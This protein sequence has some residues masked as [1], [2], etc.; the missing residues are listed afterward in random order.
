[1]IFLLCVLVSVEAFGYVVCQ[2][3]FL[4]VGTAELLATDTLDMHGSTRLLTTANCSVANAFAYDAWGTLIASNGPPQTV[5]LYTGEQFDPELGLYYLR[6]R[7][8][9]TGTGRFWTRDP[10]EGNQSDPLSLHKYLYAHGNPVNRIDPSGNMSYS[11]LAITISVVSTLAMNVATSITSAGNMALSNYQ[12]DGW[13]FSVRGNYKA[14]GGTIGGGFDLIYEKKGSSW[15]VALV[16]EF[17]TSPVSIFVRQRGAGV[18][19][20]AGPVFGMSDPQ[21]MSGAG[22]QAVWPGSVLHLLP[23]GFFK[24]NKAWGA[25]TQLA[26]RSKNAKLTDTAFA[27]GVSTSGPSFFQVGLRNNSFS[28]LYSRTGQYYRVNEVSELLGSAVKD[29]TDKASSVLSYGLDSLVE[30]ADQ[31]LDMLNGLNN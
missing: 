13:Y 8:L 31:F 18:N 28:S 27:L 4:P 20:M 26:K 11:E 14:V 19:V 7:Y 9:N 16:G 10:W 29:I 21:E 30:N 24:A 15:W 23:G 1:L 3:P 6:A 2:E 22:V 17:G 12:I 5:Y 25:M